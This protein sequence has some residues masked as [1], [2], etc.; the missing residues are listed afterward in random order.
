MVPYHESYY[1]EARGIESFAFV[2]RRAAPGPRIHPAGHNMTE[3]SGEGGRIPLWSGNTAFALRRF[4]DCSRNE[5]IP[6][7]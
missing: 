3:A 2:G 6:Q 1:D 5:S 4:Q 7:P